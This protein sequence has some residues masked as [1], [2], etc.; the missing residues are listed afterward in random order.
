MKNTL[1]D[2]FLACV[3]DAPDTLFVA[4]AERRL[5]YAQTGA[6]AR[7]RAASLRAAGVQ[8]GDRVLI[9]DEQPLETTLWLVACTLLGAVFVVIHRSTTAERMRYLLSDAEPAAVIDGGAGRAAAYDTQPSLRCV[10]RQ[11]HEADTEPLSDIAADDILETDLALLVYTSGSTGQ[12]KGIMSAHRSV[13]A[14]TTAINAFL[15]NRPGDRIGHMLP[16][17]FDYGLYQLFL[18]MQGRSSVVFMGDFHSAP[19]LIERLRHDRITGFPAMRAILVPLSRLATPEPLDELRYITSTGDYLP[20]SL[21]EKVG[22]SFP[23]TQF[24]SMYGLSEC[25]RALYMPPERLASKPQS[26]GRAIPGTRAFVIDEQGQVLPPG[27]IGELVLEGPHVMSGY[28]RAPE[29]TAAR[30]VWGPEGQ[31]RLR[32]GDLFFQDEQGDFHFVAR[33]SDVIKSR[34]FRISPREVESAVLRADPAVRECMVYGADDALLGQAI[35]A[36]VTVDDP[37]HTVAQIFALCRASIEPHLVPTRI[38][39]VDA[40]PKT[41]TGKYARRQALEV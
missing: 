17:S 12:P 14:A 10:V 18:A 25:K 31:P 37:A 33:P 22:A 24:F 15:H 27:Q 1:C 2:L 3:A 4:D 26:V 36:D 28:W 9:V 30:F 8:R 38:R 6:L 34:G 41:S 16:L 32:A 13:L 39:I 29:A 35:C 7:R 20:P 19:E 21:L 5:T 11:P 23:R 40:L